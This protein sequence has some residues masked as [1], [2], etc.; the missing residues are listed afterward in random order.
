MTGDGRRMLGTVVGVLAVASIAV[1][2]IEGTPD[3]LPGAALGSAALLHAERALMLVVIA[4]ALF[5]VLVRAARGRLPI[6]LSSTGLRYE[7]D[8]AEDIATAVTD[9]QEQLDDLSAAV[10]ALAQRL[11]TLSQRP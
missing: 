3:A 4:I 9:Q 1:S 6:E 7:S 11:D 5:S 8:T 2:L 10:A